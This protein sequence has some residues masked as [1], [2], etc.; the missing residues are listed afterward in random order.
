MSV[1][2]TSLQ[3]RIRSAT[4][5]FRGNENGVAGVE[6][7][8]IS[9]AFFFLIFVI[10]E[11]ALVFVAEEVL[12]DSV[13]TA[14]RMVRTGQVQAAGMT[15]T[16]FKDLICSRA[17]VFLNCQSA[18]FFVD[19]KTYGSFGEAGLGSP[20]E[21]NGDF[22]DEGDFAF[23]GPNDVV[24]VRAYYKWSTNPIFGDITLSNIAGGK[25]L[26]GSFA[27]FRNEPF[28]E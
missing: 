16:D 8:L 2:R 13:T 20:L 22:A 4:A 23:G 9:P 14:A 15:K 10:M 19:V 3:R 18:D 27:T 1:I 28:P 25:R 21:P 17:E 24:V 12:D 11:T 26:I 5:N 7:A 6:F